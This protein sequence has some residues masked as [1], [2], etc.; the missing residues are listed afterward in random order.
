[1]KRIKLTDLEFDGIKKNF[2]QFLKSQDKFKDYNFNG[3][4]MQVILDLLSANTKYIGTYAHF[5]LNEAFIDS[6]YQRRALA[7]KGKLLNY[8]PR[9]KQTAIAEVKIRFDNMTEHPEN[10]TILLKRGN[11][12]NASTVP[13]DLTGDNRNFVLVDDVFVYN[14]S[15]VDT[16]F[17][18]KSSTLQIYE[19]VYIQEKYKR[20]ENIINQR[21]IIQNENIDTRTLRVRVYPDETYLGTST[22]EQFTIAKDFNLINGDSAVFF[23]TTNEDD[24][25][26]IKFGNGVYG[27]SLHD[28]NIVEIS[29]VETTGEEGNGAKYFFFSG[30][31]YGITDSNVEPVIE[32]VTVSDGGREA[33]TIEELRFNIP[34]HFKQQNRLSNK[35]DFLSTLI[36][37]Y[38]NI[39]S[40]SVWGGEEGETKRYGTVFI[41]IKPKYGDVLSSRA[42]AKIKKELLT[43][44]MMLTIK[45]VL[46]D[47]NYIKLNIENTTR[48]N[49]F[50]SVLTYGEMSNR[51][52]EVINDYNKDVST[53]DGYFSS[54]ILHGKIID[55][56]SKAIKTTTSK[57]VLEIEYLPTYSTNT[58]FYTRFR[59][60]LQPKTYYTNYF[61]FRNRK[62][63]LV[64]DGNGNIQCL[65]TDSITGEEKAY[66]EYFGTIDYKKGMVRAT[67][68]IDKLVNL[69]DNYLV[70]K[71]VPIE[72]DFYPEKNTIIQINEIKV[73]VLDNK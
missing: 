57:F 62:S 58:T 2:I 33:E 19:G 11:F 20:D 49:K 72:G 54:S 28:G 12:A 3:S 39:S 60:P 13:D 64:D 30:H 46:L 61:M 10:K 25:Y 26:E 59:T 73:T 48:Y 34:N 1:V 7:S 50:N 27:K 8:L 18:Y 45:P 22:S 42:K 37:G 31:A 32:T 51:I 47:P 63:R 41:S 29:Y 71:A 9:S 70:S 67:I 56:N 55:I 16:Q 15:V 40:I 52:K 43:H 36:T 68:V 24:L 66:D 44:Q 17:D 14:R 5:L 53:F 21:F 38:G 35:Y 23:L 6:A 65:Y 69:T 4:G